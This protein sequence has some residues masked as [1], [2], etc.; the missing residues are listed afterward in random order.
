MFGD[1]VYG[2]C[3]LQGHVYGIWL[4]IWFWCSGWFSFEKDGAML[5]AVGCLV[6]G[7]GNQCFCWGWVFRVVSI[8]AIHRGIAEAPGV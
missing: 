8:L 7:A 2:I 3:H 4:W 6:V 5:L 1:A